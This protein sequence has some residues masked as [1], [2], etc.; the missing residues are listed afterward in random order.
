MRGDLHTPFGTLAIETGERGVVACGTWLAGG[1]VGDD[2]TAAR[3]HL[4]VAREAVME[5][6]DGTLWSFERVTLAPSG[7]DFQQRV[8]RALREVPFGTTQ[9]YRALAERLG[10]PRSARAVGQ[11][12]ARN[13]LGIFQPCHRIV[14]SDG[15]LTG[16]AGGLA[17]KQWLIAHERRVAEHAG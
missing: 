17:M 15:G 14:G 12:N 7:T 4:R 1:V 10:R 3:A 5:Y 2:S 16:F 6:L 9:S 8:W 11:A 13:P